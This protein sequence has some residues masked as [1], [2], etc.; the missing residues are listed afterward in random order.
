M[1]NSNRSDE[2][3]PK[4]ETSIKAKV[5]QNTCTHNL[6][7]NAKYSS[8]G[9]TVVNIASFNSWPLNISIQWTFN[10]VWKYIKC[11]EELLNSSFLKMKNNQESSCS[12]LFCSAKNNGVCLKPFCNVNSWRLP[13]QLIKIDI[14]LNFFAQNPIFKCAI[15]RCQ[16]PLISQNLI[17]HSKWRNQ[18]VAVKFQ[19]DMVDTLFT[20]HRHTTC[21]WRPYYVCVYMLQSNAM[22]QTQKCMKFLSNTNCLFILQTKISNKEMLDW[23]TQLDTLWPNPGYK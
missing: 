20:L 11:L 14:M 10:L 7:H 22:L 18:W 23:T 15:D 16:I 5:H 9:K 6:A 21:V 1:N 13:K 2:W 17:S 8:S 3:N 12:T 19:K 4:N